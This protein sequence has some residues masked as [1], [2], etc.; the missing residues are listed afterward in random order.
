VVSLGGAF[1]AQGSTLTLDGS[2]SAPPVSYQTVTA[3]GGVVFNGLA[4]N[5]SSVMFN[6]QSTRIL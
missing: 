5:V 1:S 6:G 4:V 3:T 2:N